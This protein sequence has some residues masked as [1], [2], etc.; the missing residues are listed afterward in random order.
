MPSLSKIGDLRLAKRSLHLSILGKN[1]FW[2]LEGLC[3]RWGSYAFSCVTPITV[4]VVSKNES[5]CLSENKMVSTLNWRHVSLLYVVQSNILWLTILLSYHYQCNVFT[6]YRFPVSFLLY[7]A[8]QK[9]LTKSLLWTILRILLH[10][11]NN[12]CTLCVSMFWRREAAEI[13]RR[14][15]VSSC[16]CCW[17]RRCCN[18]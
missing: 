9:N 11:K 15:T 12:S 16:R 18:Y 10:Q 1:S 2:G 8:T 17:R 14:E 4:W 6:N 13:V 5:N 3:D 7:I